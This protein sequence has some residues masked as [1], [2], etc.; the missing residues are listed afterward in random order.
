MATSLAPWFQG[1]AGTNISADLLRL[2]VQTGAAD[3]AT[4][5]RNLILS[6]CCGVGAP[7]DGSV[8]RL[9]MAL[10]LI[11]LGRGASGVRLELVDQRGAIVAEAISEFDGFFLFQRVPYGT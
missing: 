2:L 7:L 10:K 9:I 6:H 11:S 8:V 5:Q 1:Q 4:L 3:T